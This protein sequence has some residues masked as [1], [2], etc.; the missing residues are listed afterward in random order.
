M[1]ALNPEKD[2]CLGQVKVDLWFILINMLL[3]QNS[4]KEV[5]I[6]LIW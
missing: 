3:L 1:F 4:V 2:K 5:H 6:S